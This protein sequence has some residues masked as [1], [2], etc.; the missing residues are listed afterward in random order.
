VAGAKYPANPTPK[1]GV[2]TFYE[3]GCQVSVESDT[4]AEYAAHYNIP[5]DS[6]DICY[7]IK[8]R[9]CYAHVDWESY[10]RVKNPEG[11]VSPYRRLMKG[12]ENEMSGS[13]DQPVGSPDQSQHANR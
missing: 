11:E 10:L 5:D 8:V 9:N 3:C 6:Q 13:E 1:L 2:R 7:K 4:T 12:A